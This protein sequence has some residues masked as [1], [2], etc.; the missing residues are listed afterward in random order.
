MRRRIEFKTGKFM[1][2]LLARVVHL[3]PRNAALGLGRALGQCAPRLSQRHYLR[4]LTDIEQA[5]PEA[6]AEAIARQAYMRLGES[7]I[8]FLKLPSMTAEEISQWARLE[9]TE[10]LDDALAKGKGVILLTGH[11]GNWELCG[12]MM[13]LSQYKTTAIAREQED[14]ALTSLLFRTREAHGLTVVPMTDV[15]S[16]IR[17]LKRNECLGVVGDVNANIPGAFVQFL[18]RPAATYTGAAYLALTTGATILPMF[19]ERLPD[20]THI[21]RI[22]PPIPVSQTGDRNYDLLITTIRGQR[23]IE[24][25]IRRRPHDWF[26]QVQRWKTRPEDIPHPDRIPMEHRD[27]QAGEVDELLECVP[28]CH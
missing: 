7:L 18:G 28:Q 26:W 20:K 10:Y 24:N 9:G 4:V 27:L 12:A 8:E 23:I 17:V 15:R 11:M 14:T 2:F 25:E 22:G 16:C 1:L 3:L 5:F 13:G 21:C 6:N 19:D